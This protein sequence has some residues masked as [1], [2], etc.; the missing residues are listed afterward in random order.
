[1]PIK[2]KYLQL[3]TKQ[4]SGQ[5]TQEESEI[6]QKWLSKSPLH[7]LLFIEQEDLWQSFHK[8]DM[9]ISA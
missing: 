2:I 3:I 6:L 1:M 9:N 8:K 4:L 5:I 7:Q